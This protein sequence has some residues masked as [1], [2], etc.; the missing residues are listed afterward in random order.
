M[1]LQFAYGNIKLLLSVLYVIC[2][3]GI[4][5]SDN[6]HAKNQSPMSGSGVQ[7]WMCDLDVLISPQPGS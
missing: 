4:F 7:K 6:V 2:F 3:F 5:A 1:K